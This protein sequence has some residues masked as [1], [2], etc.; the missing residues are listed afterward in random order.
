MKDKDSDAAQCDGQDDVVAVKKLKRRSPS[1][2]ELLNRVDYL[3]LFTFLES[4]PC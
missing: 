4:D 3:A 1:R 2:L